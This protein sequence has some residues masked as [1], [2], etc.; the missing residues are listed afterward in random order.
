[1]PAKLSDIIHSIMDKAY[2]PLLPKMIAQAM[3]REDSTVQLPEQQSAT[4][5]TQ[6]GAHLIVVQQ[7]YRITNTTIT[8]EVLPTVKQEPVRPE[9]EES[10]KSIS[11][12]SIGIAN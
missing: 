10:D 7:P 4:L 1:M 5:P 8:S 3:S 2:P 12:N 9:P 6:K 11:I